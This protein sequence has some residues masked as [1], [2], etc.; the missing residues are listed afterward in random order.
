MKAVGE[1]E[2]L[3][4]IEMEML[5]VGDVG[6]AG[7]DRAKINAVRGE[8]R[9]ITATDKPRDKRGKT[10]CSKA[11]VIFQTTKKTVLT[12]YAKS[13]GELAERKTTIRKRKDEDKKDD[14]SSE[15][16]EEDEAEEEE[17][18][19]E[20]DDENDKKKK[21]GTRQLKESFKTFSKRE[22]SRK[23]NYKNS[24]EQSQSG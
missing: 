17:E 8:A 11:A 3:A 21:K 20:N 23:W 5:A 4:V 9:R 16:G 14:N 22:N 19:E 15:A 6:I 1:L 2:K 12:T 18:E 10:K 24:T 7:A 13:R